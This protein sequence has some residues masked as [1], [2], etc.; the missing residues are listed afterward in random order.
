[1][2]RKDWHFNLDNNFKDTVVC[3][4]NTIEFDNWSV[5][6]KHIVMPSNNYNEYKQCFKD[7]IYKYWPNNEYR[8]NKEKVNSVH[9]VSWS[10]RKVAYFNQ[11][12]LFIY[13]NVIGE[14][15][16]FKPSTYPFVSIS[17]IR[18]ELIKIQDE[19]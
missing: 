7:I 3:F 18:T 5:I 13:K 8:E 15:K 19:I 14:Y 12:Y 2:A 9:G 16:L 11:Q 17:D 4:F 10:N 6:N 1:M